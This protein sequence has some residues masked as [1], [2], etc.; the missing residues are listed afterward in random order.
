MDTDDPQIRSINALEIAEIKNNRERYYVPVDDDMHIS[1]TVEG[2][3]VDTLLDTGSELSGINLL[4]YD[5]LLESGLSP[6]NHVPEELGATGITGSAVDSFGYIPLEVMIGSTKFSGNFWI[7]EMSPKLLIG[8]DLLK[9]E[10]ITI[11]C[12]ACRVELPHRTIQL[13]EE[14]RCIRNAPDIRLKMALEI[15]NQKETTSDS[16]QLYK[17]WYAM[18]KMENPPMENSDTQD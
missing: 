7:L 3:Q 15:L 13:I 9:R 12:G 1:T 5:A 18:N 6:D 17:S 11:D 14:G 16:P 10:N 2:L 4:L 8:R